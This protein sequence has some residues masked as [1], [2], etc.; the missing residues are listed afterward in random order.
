MELIIRG[1]SLA[2][3]LEVSGAKV[4]ARGGAKLEVM[5]RERGVNERT[6]YI[7]GI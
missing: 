3:Y 7:F 4:I 1:N 2:R 6:I 5:R